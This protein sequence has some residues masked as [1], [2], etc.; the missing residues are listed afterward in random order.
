MSHDNLPIRSMTN[1]RKPKIFPQN[2]HND[3]E[4]KARQLLAIAI[5]CLMPLPF[6]VYMFTRD[7]TIVA[8]TTTIGLAA[9]SVYGYYFRQGAK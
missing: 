6:I 5:V 4:R 7:V 2:E 8:T 1:Q 3:N 9:S